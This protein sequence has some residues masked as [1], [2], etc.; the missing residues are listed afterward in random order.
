M[1]CPGTL[2]PTPP[3]VIGKEIKM[4]GF[5]VSSHQ[6]QYKEDFM[7]EV[8][9]YIQEGKLKVREHMTEGI[10]NMGKAFQE[11]MK[12]GNVGKAVVKVAKHDP[13]GAKKQ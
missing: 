3:Q 12:E 2:L 8:P 4:Q 1:V 5:I 10:E 13:F 11:M 7:K 9:G 6:G